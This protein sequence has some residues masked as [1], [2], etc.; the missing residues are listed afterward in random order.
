MVTHE[1]FIAR[2]AA[3]GTARL[4]PHE[5]DQL[6]HLKLAYGMGPSGTR[7]ITYYRRWQNGNPDPVPF[8]EICAG[9]EQD[10]IQLA[11]TTLHELGHALAGFEAGHG[12]GWK[13]ACA[14][15]GLR[16]ALAAGQSYGLAAFAPDVRLALTERWFEPE[17]K[18]NGMPRLVPASK[19]AD[20]APVQSLAGITGT[21]KPRPCGAGIG[22][23]GGRSRG[24]GSGSRLLKVTCL[25]CGY[26][27]RVANS[28][29]EKA[30]APHCPEH[31]EMSRV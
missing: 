28:W 6:A 22:T 24:V 11:G 20:G 9:C 29:L 13:E 4:E 1:Q 31:G 7:G 8:C 17:A 21:R 10:W 2:V 14:R 16:R 27:A 25:D 19:P 15:L 12:K 23:R 5:R 30:G 3:I 26:I 18:P